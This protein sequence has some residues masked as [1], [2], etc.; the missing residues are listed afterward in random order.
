MKVEYV[1][2]I[3]EYNAI[4]Y[5]QNLYNLFIKISNLIIK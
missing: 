4:K 5:Y 2:D 3:M 1:T